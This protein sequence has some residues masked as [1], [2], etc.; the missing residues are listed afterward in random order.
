MEN[1]AD[2]RKSG[3]QA[4]IVLAREGMFV[5]TP[6]VAQEVVAPNTGNTGTITVS[7]GSRKTF[8]I[9]VTVSNNTTTFYTINDLANN[10]YQLKQPIVAALRQNDEAE[11][12]ATFAKAE[13]SRSGETIDEA[14]DWLKTSVVELYELFKGEHQLGPLPKKQLQALGQYIVEKSHRSK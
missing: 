12:I 2:L 11:W 3:M 4:G 1:I 14:L 6:D 8:L 10:K 5:N 9:G 7:Q 13:L